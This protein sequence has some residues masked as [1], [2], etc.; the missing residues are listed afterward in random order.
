MSRESPLH[1]PVVLNQEQ[2]APP[3]GGHLAISG[4]NFGCHHW[5]GRDCTGISPE[6]R[7]AAKY[8]TVNRT[9][10][11]MWAHCQWCWGW[12]SPTTMGMVPPDLCNAVALL[13]YAFLCLTK[14]SPK[15][16]LRLMSSFPFLFALTLRITDVVHVLDLPFLLR[17]CSVLPLWNS[18]HLPTN[19]FPRVNNCPQ[20]FL[21]CG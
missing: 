4:D 1:T 12:E 11:S 18:F 5:R 16:S 9:K 13:Q 21:Y 15:L 17:P 3:L 2:F 7:D 6:D 10:T 19:Y 14:L 20:P 8:L